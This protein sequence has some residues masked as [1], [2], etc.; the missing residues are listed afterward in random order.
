MYR[1]NHIKKQLAAGQKSLVCWLHSA[2]PVIAEI[3]ALTGYDGT[4][5]DLEHG[6]DNY[7]SATALMQAMS[8]APTSSIIRVPWNDHVEIKRALDTGCEGIMV[9]EVNSADEAQALVS[10]CLYPPQGKRGAASV[11]NRASSYGLQNSQYIDDNGSELLVIAQIE[12]LKAVENLEAIAAVE[13]IDVLFIGHG[14]LSGDCGK[15]GDYENPAFIEA[16]AKAEDIISKSGK[17]LGGLPR[18]NDLAKDMLE[19]GYDLVISA[20][21]V[22][23]FRDAALQDLKTTRG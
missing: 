9:P 13:G 1:E 22:L 5:I 23:M 10:A 15:I 18:A 17:Y 7:L 12:S 2:S 4:V 3:V 16:L 21:D 14:D 19:R 20:S 11:L 6:P 8:A